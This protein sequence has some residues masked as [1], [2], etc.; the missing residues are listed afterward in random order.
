MG[1]WRARHA[2]RAFVRS[3]VFVALYY[4]L[5]LLAPACTL[6]LD[7]VYAAYWLATDAVLATAVRWLSDSGVALRVLALAVN[8][9]S[10]FANVLLA[11]SL[12][13]Q[14]AGFN[15]QF[16]YHATA[17]TLF[18]GYEAL[19]P[20]FHACWAYWLLLSLWPLA[21]QRTFGGGARGAPPPRRLVA[22]F[23]AAGFALNAPVLSL[24][25][26]TASHVA[27]QRDVLLVPKTAHADIRPAPPRSPRNLVLVFAEGLEATYGMPEV[28]GEDATPRLTALSEQGMRFANLRQVSHT[29]WTVGAMV[30][31]QCAF[32]M[33]PAG[34]FNTVVGGAAFAA[35]VAGATCLGDVLKAHGYRAVYLGGASLAFGNKEEFLAEHGFDERYGLRRLRPKV[36]DPAQASTFGVHDDFL[37]A[38]ALDKLAELQA[39]APFALVLLTLDTHGPFGLPSPSCG[40]NTGEGL[41]FAIRCADRL[42]AQFIGE[43]RRRHPDALVALLSDHLGSFNDLRRTAPPAA[44]RRLRFTVWGEGIGPAAIRRRGT[45]FDVTPTL[46]DL[47]GLARWTELGLGA[48]LLRFDSPWFADARAGALRVVHVL[49]HIQALAGDVVAFET[50]GPVIAVDDARMLATHRGL[51]LEEAVFAIA[52]NADGKAA[53]H[54]SFAG[55]DGQTMRRELQQ[56]AGGQLL[57]GVSTHR[58]FNR[59]LPV[60]PAAPVDAADAGAYFL[61]RMGTVDFVA[62]RLAQ[63]RVVQVR[64]GARATPRQNALL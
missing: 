60:G 32:P 63:G 54:R 21:L 43:V 8:S 40:P 23:A 29:G 52:F 16:F 47:L 36:T 62:G 53:R 30:A 42:L 44:A 20:F 41:L 25:W 45:H 12:W 39:A 3:R 37:F 31:A 61:G 22:V 48:S 13:L 50:P 9:A 51:R 10:V 59:R 34:N 56:W 5:R 58:G 19:A 38:F 26:N 27:E 33:G 17:E 55:G 14:G 18:W 35:R 11:L 15:F 46:L 49:P 24:A 64:V 6:T 2:A 7:W 57:V 4:A 1:G 28:F